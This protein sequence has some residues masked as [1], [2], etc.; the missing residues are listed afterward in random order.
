PANAVSTQIPATVFDAQGRAAAALITVLV[1]RYT[2][3]VI[4]QVYG[5]ANI[6][7]PLSSYNRNYV[8]LYNRGSTS[9]DLSAYSLQVT[10]GTGTGWTKQ[11]LAGS[12]PA[13]G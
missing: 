3:V 8:E 11:N 9:F 2:P 12:I 5:R 13:G 1:N 7:S 6:A 4:S 10:T